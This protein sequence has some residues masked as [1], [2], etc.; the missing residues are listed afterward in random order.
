MHPNTAKRTK[1]GVYGPMGWIGCIRC[2]KIQHEFV[3][4]IFE[5]IAPV[6][7]ILYRVSFSNETIPSAPKR[8]KTHY[9]MSLGSNGVDRV[10]LV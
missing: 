10:R 6:Q 9:N 2:E 3:A 4:R 5:L 1:K 8:Y 7:P